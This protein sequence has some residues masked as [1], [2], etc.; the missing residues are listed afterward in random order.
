MTENTSN[1]FFQ[2]EKKFIVGNY[3]ETLRVKTPPYL[4][5][6]DL[7]ICDEIGTIIPNSN[8]F[9]GKYV[10]SQH[11]GYGDNGTRYD[12][13]INKKGENI[14]NYLEYDGTTR[15][16]DVTTFM[17]ERINYLKLVESVGDHINIDGQNNHVL[18]YISNYL[19]VREICTYIGPNYTKTNI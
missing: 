2:N 6:S 5:Y 10:S 17:D 12:Y 1:K 11:Y 13:F 19:L 9:L 14:T 8:K 3:Y 16:R 4:G 7:E 15:Y 18:K